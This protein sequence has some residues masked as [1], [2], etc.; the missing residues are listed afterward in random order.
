MDL[1]LAREVHGEKEL[2]VLQ[3]STQPVAQGEWF[4]V[5]ILSLLQRSCPCSS[6]FA[7]ISRK[8]KTQDFLQLASFGW[9]GPVGAICT[10]YEER[11]LFSDAAAGAKWY[12]TLLYGIGHIVLKPEEVHFGRQVDLFVLCEGKAGE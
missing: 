7:E 1:Y 4:G 3:G 2:I 9:G 5:D 6:A 8:G 12:K 10:L 11:G